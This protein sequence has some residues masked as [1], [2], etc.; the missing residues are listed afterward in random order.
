MRRRIECF[1]LFLLIA[2][3][4]TAARAEIVVSID[5]TTVA[6]GGTG[7][8]DVY[9]SSTAP[10]FH[11]DRFNDYAFT[12]QITPITAGELMFAPNSPPPP[13]PVQSYSYLNNPSYV[14]YG[15]S[16]DWV[17]GQAFPPAIGGTAFTSNTGY[18]DDSFQGFDTTNDFHTV[19]LSSSSG[20]VLLAQLTL[21]AAITS[22]GEKFRVSL[23]PRFSRHG[24]SPSSPTYFDTVNS[25]FHQIHTVPYR[26]HSG[27]VT[28]G[29]SAVPEPSSIV[30]GLSAIA[31]LAC[32]QAQRRF[33][34]RKSRPSCA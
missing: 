7:V 3:S 27:I 16:A 14:F 23:V 34:M 30:Y 18:L 8:L 28:I 29:P 17:A 15:N 4:A 12:L 24:G 22:S 20:E 2:A 33:K 5:S 1:C 9:I 26:S 11:P 31:I 21:S 19:S 13:G 6:A 25:D 32:C 10:S